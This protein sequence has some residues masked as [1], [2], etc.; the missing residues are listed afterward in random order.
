MHTMIVTHGDDSTERTMSLEQFEFVRC[1]AATSSAV[2]WLDSD[3]CDVS[4]S[5]DW[6][7]HP[8]K[9]QFNSDWVEGHR[10]DACGLNMTRTT[11]CCSTSGVVALIRMSIGTSLSKRALQ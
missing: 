11:A 2:T 3:D 1:S 10:R 5:K 7:H 9:E 8:P 4:K 6:K